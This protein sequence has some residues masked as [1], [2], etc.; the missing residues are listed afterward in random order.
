MPFFRLNAGGGY[1]IE[2]FNNRSLPAFIK[3]ML[4]KRNVYFSAIDQETGEERLFS[5]NEILTGRRVS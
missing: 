2:S 3:T 5:V 1:Y 4:I